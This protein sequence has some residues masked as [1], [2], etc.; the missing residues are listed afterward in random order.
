LCSTKDWL[1]IK[2]KAKETAFNAAKTS[3]PI[4]FHCCGEH[5]LKE[6]PKPKDNQRIK[7]NHKKFWDSKKGQKDNKV[8]ANATSPTSKTSGKWSRPTTEEKKNLNRRPIDGKDYYYHFK[9]KRW[10]LVTTPQA[11]VATPAVPATTAPATAPFPNVANDQARDLAAANLSQS[12]ADTIRRM[13][14]TI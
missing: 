2:T 7:I 9:D 8:A 13:L 10:K 11:N 1:G 4:C 6:C 14:A 12:I 3:T 5:T